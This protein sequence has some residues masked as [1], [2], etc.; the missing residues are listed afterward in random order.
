MGNDHK[1]KKLVNT[2][3]TNKEVPKNVLVDPCNEAERVHFDDEIISR[4]TFNDADQFFLKRLLDR[5]DDCG[6]K[7]NEKIIKKI[8]TEEVDKTQ[9]MLAEVLGNFQEK[10]FA[11]LDSHT[12]MLRSLALDV[13]EIKDR[14]AKVE[15]DVETE[16]ERIEKLEACRIEAEARLVR[17]EKIAELPLNFDERIR[18]QETFNSAIWVSL[19]LIAAII[20]CGVATV[21]IIKYLHELGWLG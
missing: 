18:K 17:L 3:S 19:R 10:M 13:R 11:I 16:Q 7:E 5:R 4:L 8:I 14:L 6:R 9:I 12:G 15:D 2:P 1:P 20:V 21:Y